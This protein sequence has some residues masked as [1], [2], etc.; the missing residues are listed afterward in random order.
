MDLLVAL[1]STV[2]YA[3]SVG[4]MA[5]DVNRD[6]ES[7]MHT[8]SSTYFDSCV[9]LAFFIIM[10]RVL[11]GRAKIKVSCPIPIPDAENL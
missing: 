1:S 8:G 4:M 6:A 7:V 2:A 11:E 5:R 9:F 3:A 10:G